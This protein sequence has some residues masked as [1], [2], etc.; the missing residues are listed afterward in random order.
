[1]I[2]QARS[3]VIYQ[4]LQVLKKYNPDMY[5]DVS[6]MSITKIQV[7]EFVKEHNEKLIEESSTSTI[8]IKN[9]V[10][11]G[12]DV[13]NVRTKYKICKEMKQEFNN[14]S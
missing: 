2:I 8:D 14:K 3:F 6:N 13:A 7:D 12:D 5:D 9:E 4:W 11:L 10:V 1:M